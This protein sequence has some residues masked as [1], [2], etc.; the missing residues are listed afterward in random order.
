MNIDDNEKF[1]FNCLKNGDFIQYALGSVGTIWLRYLYQFTDLLTVFTISNTNSREVVINDILT[2][3]NFSHS[4]F[5][6]HYTPN[7]WTRGLYKLTDFVLL[8]STIND[9]TFNHL[10][11]KDNIKIVTAYHSST[12]KRI[13]IDGF[14][15]SVALEVE[16]RNFKIDNI[17]KVT[18]WECYGRLVHTIF[19]FEFSHLLTP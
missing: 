17:P 10:E 7:E 6:P 12:G 13:I 1:Q 5:V 9:L 19:P 14:H 11:S 2:W 3:K 4:C 18:I 8:T 16:I 15:R